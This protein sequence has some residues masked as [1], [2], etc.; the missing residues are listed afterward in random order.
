MGAVE[1]LEQGART[2][3]ERAGPAV[4]AIGRG[5]RGSGV[6]IGAGKVLTN[7]HNLRDST[8]AV[9]FGDGRTVQ[10]TA[11]A[12]DGDG[13]LAVLAVDTG[14]VTALVWG[15]AGAATT[16]SVV[17]AAAR[18][19]AGLRTTSGMVTGTEQELRG[20]RGRRIR[21]SLEHTAP[22]AKG[23]SGGPVL[24]GEG[25]LIAI[26]TRRL[27]EGFYSALPADEA[28]QARV[29]ALAAGTAPARRRLGIA[30]APAAVARRLRSA[31]GLPERDGL[32]VRG[33]EADGPA[34]RAGLREGDLLVEAA[35][36]A[37][38]D[39]DVLHEVLDAGTDG[40]DATV[41]LLVVRG[42]EELSVDV[43]FASDVA[44]DDPGGDTPA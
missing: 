40:D 9:T 13:D 23:S 5:A 38:T 41:H 10:G 12:V 35:G 8:T 16:G 37:L 26:N 44:A 15:D 42:V 32:L 7:A 34:D 31:V 3:A 33:V 19:R 25:R 20:P 29:A 17:Y 43:P 14:S 4:V 24:D 6:V 11:V 22:L 21:G 28:F 36:R 30:L 27:G 39:A 2:V 1:E 18:G